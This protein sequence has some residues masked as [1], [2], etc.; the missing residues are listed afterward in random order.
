MPAQQMGGAD[1]ST[2]LAAAPQNCTS[3][4]DAVGSKPCTDKWQVSAQEGKCPTG[5]HTLA[6][7]VNRHC[8]AATV[9]SYKYGGS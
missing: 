2:A 4:Q 3:P 5:T 7:H 9:I 6:G 8:H 1:R